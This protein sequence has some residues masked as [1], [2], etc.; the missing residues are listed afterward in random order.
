MALAAG[1]AVAR[2]TTALSGGPCSTLQAA[3]FAGIR[4]TPAPVAQRSL[5]AALFKFVP[6]LRWASTVAPAG[7]GQG[8]GVGIVQ[9]VYSKWERRA[10][11]C[12]SHVREL[13]NE[14]IPVVVQPSKA[15][16]FSDKE[17]EDAGACISA[18][19]GGCSVILGVKQVPVDRLLPGKTYMFFSHTIKGQE[20]NMPLLDACLQRR[21]RLVDYECITQGGKPNGKRLI[22]F[23]SWAGKAGM[24]NALRGL[25]ER[26]LGQGFST[27][28]L[29]IGS[30]Y[31]YGSFEDARRAVLQ[32][33]DAIRSRGLPEELAPFVFVFTSNGKASRGAQEVFELLPHQVCKP[34]S[35]LLFLNPC[36]P[37]LRSF[38]YAPCHLSSTPC[39]P[40]LPRPLPARCAR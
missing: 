10:P 17:Y 36:P 11:L 16:V 26:L 2:R 3:I 7:Q 22:A 27:P 33:G 21:V 1:R 39:T 6:Q 30:S 4:H 25:G 5:Q 37:A 24:I 34:Q 38:S 15:R 35:E 12:P 31:M 13:V 19:L 9:E 8:Q 32:L 14:G 40:Q 23:G 20:E 29:N 18:D 28:F